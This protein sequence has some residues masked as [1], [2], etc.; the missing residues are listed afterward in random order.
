[1]E[2]SFWVH[3][4]N[5]LHVVPEVLMT[6]QRRSIICE[7]L[8]LYCT[9]SMYP[10]I[11]EGRLTRSPID[12]L[13]TKTRKPVVSKVQEGM[14]ARAEAARLLEQAKKTVEDLMAGNARA[15]ADLAREARASPVATPRGGAP[16]GR[17]RGPS[18]RFLP[19]QRSPSPPP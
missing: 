4:G 13:D 5:N 10:A 17:R 18:V 7:I 19:A 9:A 1:M 14:T 15:D 12:M 8:D 11:P 6:E 3:T 2:R 16:L